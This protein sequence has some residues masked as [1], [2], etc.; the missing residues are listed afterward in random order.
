[1]PK[2]RRGTPDGLCIL[3]DWAS[4]C[5]R[6]ANDADCGRMACPGTAV[7]VVSHA[8]AVAGENSRITVI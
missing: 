2:A 3:L 8:T 1:M 5:G 6:M 4:D 7:P